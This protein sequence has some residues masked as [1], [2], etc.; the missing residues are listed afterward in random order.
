M[1]F[2]TTHLFAGHPLAFTVTAT[3]CILGHIFPFY[4]GFKGGKG[5]ACLCGIILCYDWRYFLIAL[6]IE[7]VIALT[8]NYICF[9][10]L[11]AAVAFPISYG[12]MRH[13]LWGA[14]ILAVASIFVLIRHVENLIRIKEGTEMRLSYLW[15]KE[16]EIKRLEHS[17]G[18]NSKDYL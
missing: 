13:D 7:L 9:I 5:L 4:M 8:T 6:T 17:T 16:K 2:V 10:P 1:V 12:I 18:R 3:A 15:N 11:T 14:L